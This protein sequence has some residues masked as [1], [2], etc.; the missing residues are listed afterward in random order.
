MTCQDH[1]EGGAAIIIFLVANCIMGEDIRN[2]QRVWGRDHD[3]MQQNEALT[4]A[5]LP[6]TSK[7]QMARKA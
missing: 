4:S 6:G 5:A 3:G 2:I 1:G 7:S